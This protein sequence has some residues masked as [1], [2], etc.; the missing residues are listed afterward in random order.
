MFL[1]M[2]P[3]AYELGDVEEGAT[4]ENVDEGLTLVRQLADDMLVA[5]VDILLALELLYLV[6]AD[7]DV[8]ALLVVL[9]E[10][11][12]FDDTMDEALD[13]IGAPLP[14]RVLL[15]DTARSGECLV[16]HMYEPIG[17]RESWC[18][19]SGGTGGVC[20][21]GWWRLVAED[22]AESA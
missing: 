11:R 21:C 6:N 3:A 12:Q 22:A 1:G 10:L 18:E 9:I 8:P 4:D 16:S 14:V 15:G 2:P 5:V 19:G 7:V 13:V 20:R 17:L